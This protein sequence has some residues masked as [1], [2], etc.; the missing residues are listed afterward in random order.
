LVVP[1]RLEFKSDATARLCGSQAM[2]GKRERLAWPVTSGKRGMGNFRSIAKISY[3]SRFIDSLPRPI[4]CVSWQ[5]FE[6]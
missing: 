1:E 2:P 6:N 4:N 3:E 5:E